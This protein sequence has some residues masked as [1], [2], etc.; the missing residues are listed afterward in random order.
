MRVA[1]GGRG[2]EEE[3]RPRQEDQRVHSPMT[4]D[5]RRLEDEIAK[6]KARLSQLRR[7]APRKPVRDYEF[8]RSD[9]TPVRLS[10]LF[11]GKSDL[12][13][14]HN[15]GRACPYCTLWA[16]GFSGIAHHLASRSGIALVSPDEPEVLA[17]FVAGRGW[18][19]PVVSGKDTTFTRDIGFEPEPGKCW[20]GASGFRRESNGELVLV[21][22]ATFGPGDA[23][24]SAWHL[25]ELLADG[26]NGW[27]PKYSY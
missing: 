13:I 11:G 24:C 17:G 15:M 23:F 25:F 6:L 12:L 1:G 3:Y 5:V 18:R 7:V 14:I 10:E 26:A 4:D 2:T 20:P 16:D 8:R 19:F 22:S 9:G 21:A 27:Q